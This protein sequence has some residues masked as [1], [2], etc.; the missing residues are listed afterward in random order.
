MSLIKAATLL[1]R[2]SDGDEHFS[3]IS[4]PISQRSTSRLSHKAS[5]APMSPMSKLVDRRSSKRSKSQPKRATAMDTAADGH[6]KATNGSSRNGSA[7]K[8]KSSRSKKKKGASADKEVVD[9][10]LSMSE[11]DTSLAGPSPEPRKKSKKRKGASQAPVTSATASAD[12]IEGVDRI[13]R[14]KKTGSRKKRAAEPAEG[15]ASTTKA[16][17]RKARKA[18]DEDILVADTKSKKKRR[19]IDELKSSP[20]SILKTPEKVCGCAAL[21]MS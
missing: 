13:E 8:A 9:V 5:P 4:S 19:R 12:D 15:G 7:K 20:I 21:A 17:K 3:V 1:R 6:T 11:S 14:G 16:K 18:S 10:L 2:V